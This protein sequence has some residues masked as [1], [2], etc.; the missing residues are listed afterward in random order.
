MTVDTLPGPEGR[1][2]KQQGL[3]EE[4]GAPAPG[5][6]LQGG[7]LRRGPGS[8][9]DLPAGRAQRLHSGGHKPWTAH[10]P[11]RRLDPGTGAACTQPCRVGWPQGPFEVVVSHS[12]QNMDRNTHVFAHVHVFPVSP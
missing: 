4:S 3:E 7:P 6:R 11:H 2:L 12:I 10:C 9:R 5:K 8:P 1:L